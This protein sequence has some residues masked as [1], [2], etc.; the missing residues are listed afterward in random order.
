M[1][2][3]QSLGRRIAPAFSFPERVATT[4]SFDVAAIGIDL[5]S[6]QDDADIMKSRNEAAPIGPAR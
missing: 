6:L 5:S 3:L 2:G 1:P 4:T